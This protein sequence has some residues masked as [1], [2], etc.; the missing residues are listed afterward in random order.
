MPISMRLFT[1][2]IISSVART[3]CLTSRRR[4][5]GQRKPVPTHPPRIATVHRY[6][7]RYRSSMIYLVV[8]VTNCFLYRTITTDRQ[9]GWSKVWRWGLV[10]IHS[11]WTAGAQRLQRLCNRI[12]PGV[13]VLRQQRTPPWR[14]YHRRLALRRKFHYRISHMRPVL[15]GLCALLGDSVAIRGWHG[16][17]YC[18]HHC[19]PPVYCPHTIPNH[20]FGLAY[21]F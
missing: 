1:H 12:R 3:T 10:R 19:P 11:G 14:C 21:Y 4:L 5:T 13:D 8:S 16:K 9:I 15:P 7:R 2:Y 6:S 18:T 17:I 20:F